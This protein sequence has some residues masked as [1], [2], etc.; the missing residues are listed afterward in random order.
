MNITLIIT[1]N[2]KE[3]WKITLNWEDK[4]FDELMGGIEK[5]F[6]GKDSNKGK[7]LLHYLLEDEE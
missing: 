5:Q 3:C 1:P 6:F 7:E 4:Y 2:E